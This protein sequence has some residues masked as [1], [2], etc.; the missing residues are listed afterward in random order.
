MSED[1]NMECVPV[2]LEE[3][4]CLKAT[5]SPVRV[6]TIQPHGD[7][8]Y[9]PSQGNRY[10]QTSRNDAK[11]RV[12]AF[13]QLVE[14]REAELA[15]APEYF[16]PLESIENVLANPTTLREDTIYVLPIESIPLDG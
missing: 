9:D 8:V 7:L 1:M 6:A 11:D 16:A 4:S 14:E 2:S 12:S 5:H 13:L 3:A 15:I 10:H